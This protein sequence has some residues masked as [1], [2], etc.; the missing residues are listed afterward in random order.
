MTVLRVPRHWIL[1]LLS[2]ESCG[3]V[4]TYFEPPEIGAMVELR[5]TENK[6]RSICRAV[7]ADHWP[8]RRGGTVV[9][10]EEDSIELMPIFV[11]D[12]YLAPQNG[13]YYPAHYQ[14]TPVGAVDDV[15]A[16]PDE[17]EDDFA[18]AAAQGRVLQLAELRRA[19]EEDSFMTRLEQEILEAERLGRDASREMARLEAGLNALKRRNAIEKQQRRKAA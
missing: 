8:T 11:N 16:V 14:S 17:W 5:P 15:P 3:E 4:V 13:R 19:W 9:R 2:G 10:F 18:L 6:R 1:E 12:R 7:V